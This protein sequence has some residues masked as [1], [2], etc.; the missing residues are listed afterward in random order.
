MRMANDTSLQVLTEKAILL[1]QHLI[2]S[3]S[4][5]G[6]EDQTASIL[7]SFLAEHKIPSQRVQHNVY[8]INKHYDPQLP[9]LLLNSHHDTVAPNKNYSND[10]FKSLIRHGKLFGLGSNDAGGPLV[11]LLATFLFF[12]ESK[13]PI[14]IIFVA[15]AEEEVS[16]KNGIELLLP[17]LP[18]VDMAIVGEPTQM[19]MAIAEKGLLVVDAIA[20]GKAGHA[21]RDEGVNAISKFVED[22]SWLKMQPFE[23]VS[24]MLGPVH[25]AVTVVET[26]NKQHNVV[27]EECNFVIDIRVNELYSLEEVMGILQQ[28]MQSELKARSLRLKPSFISK[29]HPLVVAG[30]SIG[31]DCYGSPTMSDMALMNFPAVKCGPGDSARSHTADEFIFVEEIG[32]GIQKYIEWILGLRIVLNQSS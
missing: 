31:M 15:S 30:V 12:Y 24:S 32:R 5:S 13:L 4:L 18:K 21:A 2:E 26:K 14:N 16:G 17:H 22:F 1:L 25:T 23:K 6:K 11:A 28:G 20:K 3:P 8:A 9:T 10:P 29:D 19:R 7:E 27:P